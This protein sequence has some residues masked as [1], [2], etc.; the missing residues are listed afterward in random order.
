MNT[1]AIHAKT[2][3]KHEKRKIVNGAKADKKSC[4]ANYLNLFNDMAAVTHI[5]ECFYAMELS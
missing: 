2:V 4:F 5:K 1:V 3:K